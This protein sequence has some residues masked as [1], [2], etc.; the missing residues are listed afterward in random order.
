MA[1]AISVYTPELLFLKLVNI[2]NVKAEAKVRVGPIVITCKVV[3]QPNKAAW[4]A[5]PDAQWTGADGKT[6]WRRTVEV[7]D[8][9]WYDIRLLI[10]N[11]FFSQSEFHKDFGLGDEQ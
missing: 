2:R 8:D 1:N 5:L 3:Q 9:V 10:L 6:S 11:E 4:V 7:D